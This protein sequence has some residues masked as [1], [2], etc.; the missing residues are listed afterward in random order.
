MEA[1]LKSVKAPGLHRWKDG[2]VR[3]YLNYIRLNVITVWDLYPL[4]RMDEILQAAQYTYMTALDLPSGYQ[5]E[6]QKRDRDKTTFVTLF[7][8]FR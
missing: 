7:G 5:V 4:P 3:L 2:S 8:T 6:V 1:S